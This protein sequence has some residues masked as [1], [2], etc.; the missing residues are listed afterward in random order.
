MAQRRWS[1][2]APWLWSV[3]DLSELT[4]GPPAPGDFGVH[5]F[6][7][8]SQVDGLEGV[9]LYVTYIALGPNPT[10]RAPEVH[11][12][13]YQFASGAWRDSNL[14]AQV[15]QAALVPDQKPAAYLFRAQDTA[16]V[17]YLGFASLSSQD[18]QIQELW[19]DQNGWHA[20]NLTRATSAPSPSPA[21]PIAY[22]AEFEQTQH[23]H[24]V[25]ADGHL[26]ELWWSS[27]DGWNWNDLTK[28]SGAPLAQPG[29][30]PTGFV[31]E[32]AQTQ[33][34]Y[35]VGQDSQLH[36]IRWKAGHWSPHEP[37]GGTPGASTTASPVGYISDDGF[38]YVS[39]VGLDGH[40]HELSLEDVWG[41]QDPSL[42]TN[43]SVDPNA[44]LAAYPGLEPGTRRIIVIP[45][46]GGSVQ[47]L[48][49]SGV[50]HW[51]FAVLADSRGIGAPDAGARPG[52]FA[53]PAAQQEYVYYP[54]IN[55]R[56]V[57]LAGP[58][59]PKPS[60]TK[61]RS[62]TFADCSRRF[63]HEMRLSDFTT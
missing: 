50:D 18:P 20:N 51:N 3:T 57:E 41:L 5:A 11:Q 32:A 45:G 28:A 17:I 31:S 13:E 7:V 54:S 27:T 39:Y 42:E 56:V 15:G 40:V 16:H 62:T 22:A 33:H 26:L 14:S 25:G 24:Y 60:Q 2:P 35:F 36:G 53:V 52:A 8:Q 10:E 43:T 46:G 49:K 61:L 29:T 44:E 9:T 34:V 59:F 48:T 23:V 58:S 47:Q 19:A 38:E 37:L 4:G 63:S 12:L 1:W 6:S 55:F 30:S 21:S